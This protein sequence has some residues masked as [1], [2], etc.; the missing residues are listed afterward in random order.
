MRNSNKKKKMIDVFKEN[1]LI[2]GFGRN[3]KQVAFQ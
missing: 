2:F 1:A 3:T